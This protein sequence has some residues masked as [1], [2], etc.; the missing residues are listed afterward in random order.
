M[1]AVRAGIRALRLH[2][3]AKNLLLFAPVVPARRLGDPEVWL[4]GVVAFFSVS[5]VASALYVV[6]DLMDVEA[7]RRHPT[8]RLRPF[9]SG[10]LSPRVGA[11]LSGALLAGG[12]ALASVAG[13]VPGV[14]VYAVGSAGYSLGLKRFPLVDVFLLAFL[15]TVRLIVGG[16]ATGIPVSDWLLA[17]AVFLFLSLAS[18]KRSAELRLADQRGGEVELAGRG[19]TTSDQS[20]VAAMGIAGSFAAAV[21]LAL[22][23]QSDVAVRGYAEPRWLWGLVPLALFW[24]LRLWLS[25]SRGYI[26]GDPVDYALRDRVTWLVG[27][28]CV[29]LTLLA[30]RWMVF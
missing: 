25:T 23:V 24:Q 2:Q 15:Y 16:E 14:V 21:I 22:Y 29:L 17:F 3:W 5:L 18:M 27:L 19:Y 12:L 7:D 6:N 30:A 8:K 10:E 9:A 11:M 13:A 4:K 20:V 26:A 28:C 1:G